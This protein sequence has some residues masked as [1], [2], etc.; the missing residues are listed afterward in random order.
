MFKFRLACRNSSQQPQNWHF[1]LRSITLIV[2]DPFGLDN[3]VG[4]EIVDPYLNWL[5]DR[6]PYFEM[7]ANQSRQFLDTMANMTQH[8]AIQ[9]ATV[10][11]PFFDGKNIPLRHYVQDV[12]NGATLVPAGQL[13][14]YI[15][16]VRSRLRGMARESL[17]GVDEINTVEALT[18]LLKTYFA[19]GRK[20]A[21]YCNDFQT[22]RMNRDENVTEFYLRVKRLKASAQAALINEYGRENNLDSPIVRDLAVRAFAKGLRDD[23]G[24]VL[25]STTPRL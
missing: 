24:M 18:D 22:V 20:Y 2:R 17:E 8:F 7:D 3:T 15:T 23:L 16:V 14:T 19:P 21:D 11:I 1:K 5:A 25:L 6:R 9:N 10:H 4:E 12:E 13:A